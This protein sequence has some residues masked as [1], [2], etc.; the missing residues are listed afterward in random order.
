[1]A[2]VVVVSFYPTFS[3]VLLSALLASFV[4]HPFLLYR[5]SSPYT[6]YT[7]T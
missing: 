6:P 3:L 2:V 1:M 5:Q 4:V 7:T